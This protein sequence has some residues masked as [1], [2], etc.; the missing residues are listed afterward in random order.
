MEQKADHVDKV[1]KGQVVW[2]GIIPPIPSLPYL[3]F[4]KVVFKSISLFL[5]VKAIVIAIIA[6]SKA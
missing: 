4:S 2:V 6:G 1:V 5:S 3:V